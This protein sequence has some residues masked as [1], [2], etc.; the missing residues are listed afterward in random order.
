MLLNKIKNFINLN[1]KP[2]YSTKYGLKVHP[3]LTDFKT[4]EISS[5]YG[6][7]ESVI[8]LPEKHTFD[9]NGVY[10]TRDQDEAFYNVCGVAIY[11][12]VCYDNLVRLKN[13]EKEKD[14]FIQIKWLEENVE[15]LDEEKALWNYKYPGQR[16]FFSSISQGFIISAFVRAWLLT[17]ELKYYKL[18]VNAY[19]FLITPIEKGGLK[20][21]TKGYD[22]WLEEYLDHPKIL[23]GHIY[24]LFGIWDLYR[25]TKDAN[26]K[27]SFDLGVIDVVNNINQFD[28]GFF[29]RYAALDSNPAN[30]SYHFTH[31]SQL[32]ILYLITGIEKLKKYSD[33]FE[34]YQYVKLYKIL[35][36]TYILFEILK[37]KFYQ[38][39]T[40]E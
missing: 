16:E 30:N 40:N 10:Q 28:L 20:S 13:K 29:S 19:N 23:N 11:S 18:A 3:F 39:K 22:F 38:K 31:I 4:A 25:V 8:L 32:K 7:H 14:F 9:S 5:T 6:D 17:Q 33:K 35:N 24:A 34:R 27:E 2:R 37:K 15:Y 1:V 26:I 21:V 12:L 36:I